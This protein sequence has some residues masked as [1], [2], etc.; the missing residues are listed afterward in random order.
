M[1][2]R[3]KIKRNCVSKNFVPVTEQI[4]W[5]PVKRRQICIIFP[6]NLGFFSF[7][8]GVLKIID[9]TARGRGVFM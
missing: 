1:L 2:K 3:L 4:L 8:S 5:F 6:Y 9:Y 7:N